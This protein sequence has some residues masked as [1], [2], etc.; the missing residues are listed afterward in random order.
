MCVRVLC[1]T[2]GY[3]VAGQNVTGKQPYCAALFCFCQLC[4]SLICRCLLHN[5]RCNYMKHILTRLWRDAPWLTEHTPT[6]RSG[7]NLRAIRF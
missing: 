2:V 5:P 1:V 3:S 7:A 6:D 4:N